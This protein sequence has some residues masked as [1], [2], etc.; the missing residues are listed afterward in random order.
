MRNPFAINFGMIPN[1]RIERKILIDEIVNEFTAD[2]MQTPCYMLTGVRGTGKTVTL[3]E[4]EKEI[5]KEEHWI[6]I[7]LNSSRDML[8]SLVSKLYDSHGKRG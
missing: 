6:I 1:E 3:T 5:A 7:R 4:I 2:T 8:S